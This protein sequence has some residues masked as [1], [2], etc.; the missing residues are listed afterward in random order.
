MEKSPRALK[1][2]KNKDHPIRLEEKRKKKV[3]C[4]DCP[5]HPA[6]YRLPAST[7]SLR[8]Q[9]MV[10][11]GVYAVCQIYLHTSEDAA[12]HSTADFYKKN[13]PVIIVTAHKYLSLTAQISTSGLEIEKE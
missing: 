12:V 9:K 2:S 7:M 6:L 11:P 8:V 5:Y 10:S 3:V 4:T 1:S 13:I